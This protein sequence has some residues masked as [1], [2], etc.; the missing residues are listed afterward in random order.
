MRIMTM[1][2]INYP[3]YAKK[4]YLNSFSQN[5][6]KKL[7][8]KW[9]KKRTKYPV[10]NIFPE[11]IEDILTAEFDNLTDYFFDYENIKKQ[12]PQINNE[13]MR[14]F[15]YNYYYEYI[16]NFFCNNIYEMKL[17]TC[18]YCEIQTIGIYQKEKDENRLTVDLDHFYPKAQCPILALSLKNFVPTCQ[19]CNSRLKGR[20]NLFKFYN[21][22]SKNLTDEQKKDYLKKLS[23]TSEYYEFYKKSLIQIT[24]MPGFTKRTDLFN[25]V[26][27]IKIDIDTD[28]IYEHEVNAFNLNQL[29]NSLPILNEALNILDLK[30]KY[31]LSKIHEIKKIFDN[32]NYIITEEEIEDIIFHKKFNESPERSLRKLK[33]D[34]LE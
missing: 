11:F 5:D 14:I 21:L 34:L 9:T 16:I 3:I 15:N 4:E 32:S 29:Y 28:E 20:T 12:N 13:L 2:R 1:R 27:N 30:Q 17:F 31:P 23:P 8:N 6:L 10:L 25:N 24:P 33:K 19:V 18:F 26:K 22:N 7:Q